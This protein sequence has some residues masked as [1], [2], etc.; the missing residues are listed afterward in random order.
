MTVLEKKQNTAT[1]VEPKEDIHGVLDHLKHEVAHLRDVVGQIVPF[2]R[3]R[4]DIPVR[5]EPG[6]LADRLWRAGLRDPWWDPASATMLGDLLDRDLI[7]DVWPQIDITEN[8]REI[9]VRAELPGVEEDDI[10]V[11]VSDNMLTI[12]GEKRSEAEDHEGD[13]YRHECSYGSFERAIPLACEVDR[14]NVEA[15]YRRGVLTVT[16][17]KSPNARTRLK[18]I[19]VQHH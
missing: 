3:R 19:A 11:S 16:L 15:T 14:D 7:E 18:H 5:R 9:R 2:R 13:S 10:D 17:P 6:A 8:D 4:S 1:D 12:R